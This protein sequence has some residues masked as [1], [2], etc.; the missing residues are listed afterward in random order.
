MKPKVDRS[1]LSMQSTS[2]S[3]SKFL[4][5]VYSQK[6][7]LVK[8]VNCYQSGKNNKSIFNTSEIQLNSD[9]INH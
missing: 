8:K 7:C 3:L 6:K 9:G 1:E 5:H 2:V 4:R